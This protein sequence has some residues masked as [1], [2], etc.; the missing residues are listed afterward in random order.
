MKPQKR[1]AQKN[2]QVNYYYYNAAE[3]ERLREKKY[4]FCLNDILS[5]LGSERSDAEE[6]N[7]L[8]IDLD[9]VKDLKVVLD[10][11]KHYTNAAVMDDGEV[12][13][14]KL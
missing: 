1:A 11:N 10:D 13:Y 5:D 14:I 3:I 8:R 12:I 4:A 7:H 9:H 6:D 2:V